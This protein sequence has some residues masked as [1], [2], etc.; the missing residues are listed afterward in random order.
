MTVEDLAKELHESAR[1]A[2]AKNLVVRTDV[3]NSGFIEWD[4]L[5]EPARDGRRVQATALLGK[6]E[7]NPKRELG[8][9][10]GRNVHYVHSSGEHW[11]GIV[12]N[13]PGTLYHRDGGELR[14]VNT[15]ITEAIS[16]L[17]DLVVFA[18]NFT[19]TTF[20]GHREPAVVLRVD[21]VVYD[22]DTHKPNTWH[23][24]ERV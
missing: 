22:G 21:G 19:R 17:V 4:D 6:L 14:M 16:G 10:E 9:I 7:I 12:S 20:D 1:E 5:T 24:I 13:V 8:M 11:A 3:P 23:F 18:K 2:V 15:D